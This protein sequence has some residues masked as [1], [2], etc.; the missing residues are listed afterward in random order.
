MGGTL[1]VDSTFAPPPLQY[2]FKWGADCVMHSG[3]FIS[4]DEPSLKLDAV[5]IKIFWRSFGSSERN[6]GGKDA[7]RERAGK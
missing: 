4:L 3:M 5:R 7:G 2:P 1:I 6:P